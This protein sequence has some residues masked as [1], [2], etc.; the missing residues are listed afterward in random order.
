MSGHTFYS[1]PTFHCAGNR[2]FTAS[3]ILCLN[4]IVHLEHFKYTAWH[5]PFHKSPKLFLYLGI[6]QLAVSYLSVHLN[7]ENGEDQLQLLTEYYGDHLQ[8]EEGE[9]Q[10]QLNPKRHAEVGENQVQFPAECYGDHLQVEEGEDQVKLLT[11]CSGDPLQA[12]VGEDQ[13]QLPP[14]CYGDRRHVE[15]GEDPSP[16]PPRTEWRPPTGRRR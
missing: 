1:W 14:E 15:E 3:L 6:V 9:N 7:A 4:F 5:L 11:E 13:V 8:A 12:E 10:V 2:L 16:T